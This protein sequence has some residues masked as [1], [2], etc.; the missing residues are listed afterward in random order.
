MA[1]QSA[2]LRFYEWRDKGPGNGAIGQSGRLSFGDYVET[3][4]EAPAN[5]AQG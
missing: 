3:G 5:A 4:E 1:T 2:R